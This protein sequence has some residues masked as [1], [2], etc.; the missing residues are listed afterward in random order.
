MQSQDS[1]YLS[2]QPLFRH[3]HHALTLAQ[4]HFAEWH[5]LYEGWSL[6]AAHDELRLQINAGIPTTLIALDGD[7]VV[8]SVSLIHDDH[9]SG[10]QHLTPWLA[11]LYVRDD[12]RGRGVGAKLVGAAQQHARSLEVARLYLFT[13]GQREFYLDKGFCDF[14]KATAGGEAVTVMACDL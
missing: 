3:P 5:H 11:S 14:A 2:I 9:L 7:D 4:W 1:R 12:W 6:Q 10:F 8:G 13:P